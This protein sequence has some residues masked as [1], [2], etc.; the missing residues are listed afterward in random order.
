MPVP[1]TGDFYTAATIHAVLGVPPGTLRQWVA[2][3]QVRKLGRDRYEAA[4]V[5]TRWRR[6][7]GAGAET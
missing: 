3:G 7:Q 5:L 6:S 4:S 2:R 1:G